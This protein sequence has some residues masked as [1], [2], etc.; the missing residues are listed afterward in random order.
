MLF[1]LLHWDVCPVG[2]LKR[3]R[4]QH[5]NQQSQGQRHPRQHRE[6]Y[7]MGQM[8]RWQAGLRS[9][10]LGSPSAYKGTGPISTRTCTIYYKIQ[11]TSN[12]I[13]SLDK[14]QKPPSL[15][16]NSLQG[17]STLTAFIN[18]FQIQISQVLLSAK[19]SYYYFF[20]WVL[21]WTRENELS[22][23]GSL[24]ALLLRCFPLSWP[25]SLKCCRPQPRSRTASQTGV[26]AAKWKQHWELT[27]NTAFFLFVF[28]LPISCDCFEWMD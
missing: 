3:R 19:W 6:N 25:S 7:Q 8:R 28:F 23:G 24:S 16:P 14:R 20:P 27:W 26:F 5:A 10:R 17:I 13:N 1:G 21:F 11:R 9:P 12:L 15:L 4:P 22:F 18:M 2:T